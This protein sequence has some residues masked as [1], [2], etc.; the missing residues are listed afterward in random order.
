LTTASRA[1]LIVCHA[2]RLANG[3]FGRV[4]TFALRRQCGAV[5]LLCC[6]TRLT[7][8]RF[9]G[10]VLVRCCLP[11]PFLGGVDN[12]FAQLSCRSLDRLLLLLR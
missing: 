1:L 8:L 4:F 2:S 12:E 7:A 6:D 11:S 5:A 9:G 3:S 10:V